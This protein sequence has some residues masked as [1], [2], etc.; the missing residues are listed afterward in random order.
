MLVAAMSA[1]AGK[2]TA[3]TPAPLPLL[4]PETIPLPRKIL[5]ALPLPAAV[6]EADSD[7]DFSILLI[8]SFWAPPTTLITFPVVPGFFR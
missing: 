7:D 8:S 4:P 2:A 6:T 5:G 1:V 3:V